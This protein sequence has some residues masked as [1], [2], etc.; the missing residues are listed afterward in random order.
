MN[1]TAKQLDG[2]MRQGASRG[3][4]TGS[5]EMYG[6]VNS[7]KSP[8]S[9]ARKVSEHRLM[10]HRKVSARS[11]V[12]VDQCVSAIT[13]VEIPV[14]FCL[15]NSCNHVT[16]CR[17]TVRILRLALKVVLQNYGEFVYLIS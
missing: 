8:A 6:R 16:N 12:R 5:G 3:T 1:R 7:T 13:A 2:N 11:R 17:R 15:R 10:S 4:V 14:F 9:G